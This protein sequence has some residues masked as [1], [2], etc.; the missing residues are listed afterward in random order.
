M[1]EQH[2]LS[3]SY[4]ICCIG[5]CQRH[6]RGQHT[7]SA[8]YRICRIGESV[9]GMGGNNIPVLPVSSPAR[10][11]AFKHLDGVRKGSI[12]WGY[13]PVVH[14]IQNRVSCVGTGDLLGVQQD[15]DQSVNASDSGKSGVSWDQ[16]LTP[17]AC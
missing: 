14:R 8:S 2:T 9:N 1:G 4:A 15:C 5:E 16:R 3:A 10:C 12:P 13:S 7:L 11:V 6:G 17:I